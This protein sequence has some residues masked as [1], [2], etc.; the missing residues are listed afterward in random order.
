MSAEGKFA[1]FA[2]GLMA[3]VPMAC[4]RA[5]EVPEPV[6]K[7]VMA[8]T[9]E[10]LL[11]SGV[12]VVGYASTQAPR[13]ETV[14]RSHVM[15][16]GN[17]GAFVLGHIYLN[18]DAI[19]D[20]QKLN[21]LHEMVHDATLKFRLFRTVSNGDVRTMVEALADQVTEMAAESPYRPGCVTQ[22]HFGISGAELVSLATR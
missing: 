15:L 10:L 18:G 7:A 12:D 22:R 4:A 8:Q 11:R 9:E 1:C 20:C 13:V 14:S 2:L 3:L 6:V 5:D 19:L 17:D 21:L 16:F